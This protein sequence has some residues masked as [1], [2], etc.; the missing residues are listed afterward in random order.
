MRRMPQGVELEPGEVAELARAA[1][2]AVPTGP[3]TH[4]RALYLAAVALVLEDLVGGPDAAP[5]AFLLAPVGTGT[6]IRGAVWGQGTKRHVPH[7][8]ARRH[9]A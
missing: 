6:V 2:A 5:P 3:P 7:A 8:R 1:R 9:G 4:P